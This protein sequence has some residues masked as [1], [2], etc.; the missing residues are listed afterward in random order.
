[1]RFMLILAAFFIASGGCKNCDCG[2]IMKLSNPDISKPPEHSNNSVHS[3]MNLIVSIAADNKVSI[4]NNELPSAQLD[5]LLGIEIIKIRANS[6]DT[7]TLVIDADPAA[8]Y[9]AVFG[10]MKIAKKHRAKVVARVED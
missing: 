5:S 9:G 10:L 2:E 3:K 6:D 7:V 1:M 4:G 8:D